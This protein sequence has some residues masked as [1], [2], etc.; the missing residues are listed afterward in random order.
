MRVE[1][2][3]EEKMDHFSWTE[4]LFL[5]LMCQLTVSAA[6][7]HLSITVVIGHDVT[8]SC[9]NVIGG[10]HNCGGTIWMYRNK[11][12]EEELVDNGEIEDNSIS[13]RLSVTENCSLVIK[14][15][16]DDDVGRY[17]CRQKKSEQEQSSGFNVDLSIIEMTE[18]RYDDNVIFHCQMYSIESC[19]PEVEWVYEGKE[20]IHK[21]T[22]PAHCSAIVKVPTSHFNQTSNLYDLLKCKVTDKYTLTV[23]LFPFRH[24]CSDSKQAD[25]GWLYGIISVG[26][27]VILSIMMI[28][29]WKKT[30]GT[31][32]QMEQNTDDP[33]DGVSYA[34][35]SYTRM[36]KSKA[37]VHNDGDEGDNVTY[38]SVNVPSTRGASTD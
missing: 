11:E 8:L 20:S 35:I 10:Q 36:T 33:E 6:G 26:L 17:T 7:P 5:V 16:T 2:K 29:I 32:S 28:I 34:S 9:G 12:R 3:K 18:N 21:V 1:M 37:K 31:K 25:K 38:S 23:Q 15:V 13:D 30:K 27:A 19:Q 24:Q 4:T 14:Q 22:S